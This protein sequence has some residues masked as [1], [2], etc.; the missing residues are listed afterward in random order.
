MSAPLCRCVYVTTCVK[1]SGCQGV[2][3]SHARWERCL[4]YVSTQVVQVLVNVC[5]GHRATRDVVCILCGE[6]TVPGVFCVLGG[7]RMLGPCVTV[8]YIWTQVSIC[9]CVGAY[10]SRLQGPIS[11]CV[12]L[13][14]VWVRMGA[15]TVTHV[16]SY[17]RALPS[18]RG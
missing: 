6:C 14:A 9:L 11:I 1:T 2:S 12:C 3:V 4:L 17:V 10:V 16:F 5:P 13:V 8:L 7:H 15:C 18:V